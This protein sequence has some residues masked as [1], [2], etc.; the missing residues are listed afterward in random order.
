VSTFRK[1]T[2]AWTELVQRFTRERF[3]IG[4]SLFRLFGGTAILI[5]YLTIHAQ[6]H[7][8]F[9][10]EGMLPW[11]STR[12]SLYGWSRSPLYF[13][14]VFHLGAVIAFLWL[15]GFRTRLM[16]P[17]NLVFW[18]SLLYRNYLLGDG[19][20]NAMT[21]LLFYACFAD[22]GAYFSVDAARRA[23]RD[24]AGSAWSGV[25]ALTHN[26]AVLAV[27]IQIAVIYAVAGLTKAFGETWRNGTA[28]YFAW[29]N[30]EFHLPGVSEWLYSNGP[31]LAF[32]CYATVFFQISFPYFLFLNRWTRIAVVFV[33]ITFHLGI[34]TLMG[35]F[36][37][38]L[39]MIAGDVWLIPDRE[40]RTLGSWARSAWSGLR[41]RGRALRL[42]AAAHRAVEPER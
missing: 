13:E 34:M 15:I 4:A 41:A 12:Y 29:R 21:L 7:Y 38:G 27:A 37:F 42:S 28:L 22:V 36:T 16:T 17:L 23:A 6:R 2:G 10:P 25:V 11:E 35:L 5:E 9:G 20:D 31:V 3:L 18:R 19:G 1:V 39:F 14:I 26:V 33:A 8:L 32:L 24:G 40:Y 30:N